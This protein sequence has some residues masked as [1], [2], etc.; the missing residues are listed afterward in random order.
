MSEFINSLSNRET[1]LSIW[2]LVLMCTLML[3]KS[4]RQSFMGVL[5]AF[6]VRKILIVFF[7]FI[8]YVF[9][10]V[11]ILFRAGFWESSLIKDTL[12][13][14]F[15]F[16]SLLL[17]NINKV[18]SLSYLG[19]IFLDAIKWAIIIEF[20]VSFYTF[21]LRTEL[22]IFPIMTFAVNPVIR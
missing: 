14:M 18:K 7:M 17:V 11:F 15:G 9:I 20:I 19:K 10:W 13:W 5:K 21:S 8:F 1:A 2:S 6:C 16:A 12:L 3:K 22:I 4:I